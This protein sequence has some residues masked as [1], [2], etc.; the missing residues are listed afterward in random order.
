MKSSAPTAQRPQSEGPSDKA[1]QVREMFS[2]IARRYDLLNRVLSLGLDGRWRAEATREAFKGQPNRPLRVLDVATGTADLA[3]ALKRARPE[4]EVVGVDF[5]EPML[6]IGRHKVKQRGLELRLEQGDGLGLSYEAERFDV[7]TI[8]YGLRNFADVD[9][10]IR[11]FYRVLRP[12]GR[13]VVLEFPPPPKGVFG[14]LFRLYFLQVLP[15]LG[16]WLSGR[17]SAYSYLPASVLQFPA[18]PQ[19]AARMREAGFE[20]VRFRLQT[21]GVSALHSATKPTATKP[22][23]TKPTVTKPGA[24]KPGT[25]NLEPL[26]A[27]TVNPNPVHPE[28]L[29]SSTEHGAQK[30]AVTSLHAASSTSHLHL[31]QGSD[32]DSPP[33]I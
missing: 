3:I 17:R 4:A 27:E 22:T 26:S 30:K 9:G 13:L 10:G 11:E 19:L 18:P 16:G 14:R 29:H 8:A 7:L 28:P 24:S 12:G 2:A 15:R 25:I 1:T 23:V 31:P 33:K 32:L 5:A 6:E 21:F 20:N